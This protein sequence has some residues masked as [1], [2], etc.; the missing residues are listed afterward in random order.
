MKRIVAM[1]A[2]AAMFAFVGTTFASPP[3]EPPKE[4]FLITTNTDIE[5]FGTV[6][7]KESYNT[8]YF[9][10]STGGGPNSLQPRTGGE[11]NRGAEV[12]YS[13]DFKA[14]DGITRFVKDFAADSHNEPNLQV[15]K[16]IGYLADPESPAAQ[17]TFTEK[18]GLSVVA[19]GDSGLNFSGLLSLCPWVTSSSYP[20]TNEGIAAGSS[21]KV[22]AIQNFNT[23]SEVVSTDIPN[24]TYTV[25]AFNKEGGFAGVGEIQAAFVVELFEGADRWVEVPGEGPAERDGRVPG[26][27]P[28]IQSRTTYTETASAKGVWNFTK[29]MEYQSQFP[30]LGL[31][32]PFLRVP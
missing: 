29:T 28:P 9:A 30:E 4:G 14:I 27:V 20:A 21:F 24:L 19:A 2:L 5:C 17:A 13:E 31:A 26:P 18:V 22:T 32:N 10:R 12:A 11:F 25:D 15:A 23:Q 1:I 7:E 6:E 3:V 8:T 16:V